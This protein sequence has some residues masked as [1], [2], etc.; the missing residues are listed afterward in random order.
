MSRPSFL[1]LVASGFL[2]LAAL[3]VAIVYSGELSPKSVVM[4]LLL[5][6]I[7]VSVHSLQH[8]VEEI[9]YR[10]NPLRGQWL[11]TQGPVPVATAQGGQCPCG[12]GCRCAWRS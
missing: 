4:I 6:A 12:P 3:I 8:S 1:G 10:F 2:I 11:P 5:F 7:A 9:Y